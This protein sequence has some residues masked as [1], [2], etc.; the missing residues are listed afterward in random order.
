MAVFPKEPE[1]LVAVFPNLDNFAVSLCSSSVVP[2]SALLSR[3]RWVVIRKGTKVVWKMMMGFKTLM[4]FLYIHQ[5]EAR[6]KVE[7][8]SS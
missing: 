6:E 8:L 7:F 4:F 3:E 2:G 1:N 5:W